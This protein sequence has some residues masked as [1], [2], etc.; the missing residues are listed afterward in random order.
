MP[1]AVLEREFDTQE[2]RTAKVREAAYEEAKQTMPR[3]NEMSARTSPAMPTSTQV[4]QPKPAKNTNA[5][6]INAYYASPEA[7]ARNHDLFKDYEYVSGELVKKSPNSELSVPLFDSVKNIVEEEYFEIPTVDKTQEAVGT[8][9]LEDE[10][11][12]LPTR[13]TMGTVIRPAALQE[14]EQVTAVGTS[15]AL[16]VKLKAVLASVVAAIVLVLTLICVNSFLLRSL[17]SDLSNLKGRVA[18]ERATYEALKEESD[19][20]TDPDSDIVRE[21]AENNGMTR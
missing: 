7:P 5:E 4:L 1:T 16:S 20:Y 3:A 8:L 19:L 14:M 2:K 10:D 13:R 12:A 11:D 6:R 15:S 18:Q 17:D 21:W 9:E